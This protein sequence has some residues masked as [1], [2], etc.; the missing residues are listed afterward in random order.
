M[1]LENSQSH[2][3][4]ISLINTKMKV[5]GD[6]YSSYHQPLKC[7]KSDDNMTLESLLDYLAS[8]SVN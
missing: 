7:E 4:D 8:K 6:L 5:L 1:N 2:L 3:D